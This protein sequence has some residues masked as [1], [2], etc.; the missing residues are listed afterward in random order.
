MT[1]FAKKLTR[2]A[3]KDWSDLRQ[4]WLDHIPEITPAGCRPEERL[5]DNEML[6]HEIGL[7]KENGEHRFE[8]EV[9]PAS[10]LLH[11]SVFAIHT[12]IRVSCE[13]TRQADSGLPTWSISTAH[14]ASM[15]ALRAVVGL[16]GIAYVEAGGRYVL[17]DVLPSEPKGRRTRQRR[18]VRRATGEIQLIRIRRMEHRHWWLVFQRLLRTSESSFG[19]WPHAFDQALKR[20]NVRMLSRDRNELHYR[21]AW[22]HED[23]FDAFVITS[24]GQHDQDRL[25]LVVDTLLNS[26]GS[27][28]VLFLNQILLW[29]GIGML[30]DLATSSSRVRAE[31]K[32]MECTVHRF[33]NPIM[34]TWE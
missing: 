8:P 22:F 9:S 28:G 11:E 10:H 14:H 16:C 26:E 29:S 34:S 21:G 25:Q 5:A 6:R 12:A 33:R 4:R 13:A 17:M 31:T 19:C 23:L 3:A 18:G 27:D 15:L 20:C 24:F 30:R 7:V 2:L 1:D 32:I